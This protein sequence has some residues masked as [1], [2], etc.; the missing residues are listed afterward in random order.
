MNAKDMITKPTLV[1]GGTG[2]TGR[3]IVERLSARGRHESVRV[4]ANRR[5][6]GRIGA[7]GRPRSET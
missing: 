3:R 4:Q 2:K 7:R 5:S 1:L 6:I